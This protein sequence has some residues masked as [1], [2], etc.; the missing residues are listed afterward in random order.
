[1]KPN[2]HINMTKQNKNSQIKH[3]TNIWKRKRKKETTYVKKTSIS[4]CVRLSSCILKVAPFMLTTCTKVKRGNTNH[5]KGENTIS[6][7]T[8]KNKE[9]II[10]H[11]LKRMKSAH[12]LIASN[13]SKTKNKGHMKHQTWTTLLRNIIG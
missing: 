10:W 8:S 1:M 3:I 5:K 9:E 12:E 11:L 2:K 13:V 6:N 4:C 7:T